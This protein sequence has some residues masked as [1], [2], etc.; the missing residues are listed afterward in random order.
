MRFSLVILA[1]LATAF[2]TELEETTDVPTTLVPTTLAQTTIVPT[3]KLGAEGGNDQD[4][5]SVD[6]DKDD[7][8][9]S[10][11]FDDSEIVDG[12]VGV[13]SFDEDEEDDAIELEINPAG[14]AIKNEEENGDDQLSTVESEES[15]DT[16]G[17]AESAPP[18]STQ[19]ESAPPEST[20]PES[21]P[22]ESSIP[23][24]GNE[25]LGTDVP[26]DQEDDQVG[27]DGDDGLPDI[28]GIDEDELI[29]SGIENPNSWTPSPTAYKPPTLRPAVP[30]I[31]TDDDPLKGPEGYGAK[32]ED[33]F[34]NESTIDEM[35][36]D[37]NV[38][39]ALS[40]VFGVMFFFSVFVA[41]QM[42]ENS[43]GCCASVCRITVA[44]WC[45]LIRCICYPCR[46]MCGCTDASGGQHMM[47]P[48]DGHFTHD[49]ELS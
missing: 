8:V 19:P 14:E 24:D 9:T 32:I 5:T 20:P 37:K 23:N 28:E 49:L 3:T 39:I 13:D 22:P 33:W 36:H 47:V 21:T 35:E 4:Q 27:G 31:P 48:D 30:Y 18:E 25:G 2:G 10:E 11:S 46:S 1:Y 44:C 15:D 34:S 12:Q 41:Y 26:D 43:D 7:G 42:L 6:L 17:G 40:V 38:V 29:P 16:D 45:G